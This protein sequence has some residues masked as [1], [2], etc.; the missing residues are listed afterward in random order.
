MQIFRDNKGFT[1]VELL[2]VVAIIAI[3]G[4]I[5]APNIFRAVER[6]KVTA[7]VADYRSIKSAAAAY[8]SDTGEWPSGNTEGKDPG[9][10]TEPASRVEGWNG[11]YL[12][13]WPAKNP[14]NGKYAFCC[15]ENGVFEKGS[16]SLQ[17]DNVPVDAFKEL[18]E[19]LGDN[20]V[21]SDS[22]NCLYILISR[23]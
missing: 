16:V 10:V 12:E 9:F 23:N 13:S 21:K 2:T 8:Y 4:A 5:V 19:R 18:Q 17:L 22:S 20:V 3:L 7:V 14:W 11:P 15:G 1:L 6:S